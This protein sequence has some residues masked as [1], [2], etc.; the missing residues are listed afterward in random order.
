MK[1]TRI[2]RAV[3]LE[4]GGLLHLRSCPGRDVV[5]AEPRPAQAES[6]SLDADHNHP[7]APSRCTADHMPGRAGGV[8]SL[9]FSIGSSRSRQ[10]EGFLQAMRGHDLARMTRVCRC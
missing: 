8:S 1:E 6:V 9:A 5:V 3:G 7:N 2:A 10:T 4:I